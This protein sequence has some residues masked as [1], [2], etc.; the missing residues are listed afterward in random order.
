M[1]K[2]V[3]K[4]TKAALVIMSA[5]MLFACIGSLAKPKM[6]SAGLIGDV[7]EDGIVNSKDLSMVQKIIIGKYEVKETETPVE[8]AEPSLEPVVTP[9]NDEPPMQMMFDTLDEFFT[10]IENKEE[11]YDKIYKYYESIEEDG[12]VWVPYYD[13]EPV[14]FE[15]IHECSTG[16]NGDTVKW[17]YGYDYSLEKFEE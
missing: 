10:W 14:Q 3:T 13:G 5:I 7:N 15:K 12:G 4:L 2:R 17:G 16:L 11:R 9:S 6:V 8:T 1:N